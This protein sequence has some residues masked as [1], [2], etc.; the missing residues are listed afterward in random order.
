MG[1]SGNKTDSFVKNYQKAE[2]RN[3]TITYRQGSTGVSATVTAG[4]NE[5][6]SEYKSSRDEARGQAIDM[7]DS[8]N[9]FLFDDDDDE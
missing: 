9:N 2:S 8:S 1:K 6:R 5:Y 7:A 3:P 4:G